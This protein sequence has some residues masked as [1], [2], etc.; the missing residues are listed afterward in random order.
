MTEGSGAVFLSYASEDAEAA[1]RICDALRAAGVEVWFDQSELRGGDAWDQAIRRQIKECALFVPLIS[2]HTEAR[3]VGYFRREWHLAVDRMLDFAEDQPFLLPVVIDDT[4]EATSRVPDRFRER[5]WT[6]LEGGEATPAWVDRTR[7][8]LTEPVAPARR[9]VLPAVGRWRN[10]STAVVT[11]SA[12]LLVAVVTA[13]LW[14]RRTVTAPKALAASAPATPARDRRT[15]AVLP[16]DNLSGRAEDAYLADGLQAEVLNTLARL[17]EL[18]VISRTSTLEYKG[19]AHNVRDIGYRLGVG[20]ILEGSIRRDGSKLRFSVQLVDTNNDRPLLAANYDR[21]LGHLLD[22]QSAV[23]R[24]VANSLLA[25]L[26]R[27]DRGELERVGTGNGDAY[28]LY[29]RAVVWFELHKDDNRQESK[30][31]PEAKRL[32][33][34][35]VKLDPQYADAYALLSMVNGLQDDPIAAR[36][37]FEQAL[38]IDPDLPEGRLARAMYTTYYALDPERALDDLQTVLRSRPNSVLVHQQLGFTLRR[39]GRMDEALAHF[40]RAWDLDPL[41]SRGYASAPPI[42]FQPLI[43]LLGLRRWPEAIQQTE[44]HLRRFPDNA[45]LYLWN[46]K[47]ASFAQ[48]DTEPMRVAL[49]EHGN[50][51]DAKDRAM[52][53]FEVALAEGRYLDAIRLE[54]IGWADEQPDYRET[55]DGILYHAAG[56][57]GRAKQSF[58]MAE[59]HALASH[60]SEIQDLAL[61]QSMLGKHAAALATIDRARAEDPESRDAVNGPELSFVRSVI[62]L[63]AGRRE[64][65]YAEANRLLHVPFGNPLWN[66]GRT[67]CI[68]LL[69]K[70]DA[71][72][73]ELL[74]RPPRL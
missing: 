20:S 13:A 41:N 8:L 7:R 61:A 38:A 55:Y 6:R 48:H 74:Y 23:A 49:R 66:F 56:D 10:W 17:R 35:A 43:T 33:E 51:I 28:D 14:E 63:R 60:Q 31:L 36:R 37:A 46:A 34:A 39:L 9:P 1:Q 53:E 5:Q 44:L 67:N 19:N 73:A 4:A 52:I 22:L 71:H 11:L 58:L 45:F 27:T 12:V 25:T 57:E 62:L 54:D 59:R 24:Q 2:A 65:A 50:R 72:F 30:R 42:P 70:N 64:E 15:I 68:A 47:I 40:A 29:L 16:F 69:V 18:S 32:L 3:A 21:D 26:S